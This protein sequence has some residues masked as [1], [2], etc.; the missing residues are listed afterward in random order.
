MDPCTEIATR[1]VS[2][3]WALRDLF[4]TAF[5]VKD[6]DLDQ[7]HEKVG[8]DIALLGRLRSLAR[9]HIAERWPFSEAS[10]RTPKGWQRIVR[11]RD[12]QFTP[13]D[14]LLKDI[15]TAR[16]RAEGQKLRTTPFSRVTGALADGLNLMSGETTPADL[17]ALRELVLADFKAHSKA[18][19]GLFPHVP[20]QFVVTNAAAMSRVEMTRESLADTVATE[21]LQR[22]LL[23]RVALDLDY[24]P[25]LVRV[26]DGG[27]D[28]LEDPAYPRRLV[29]QCKSANHAVPFQ[30][31]LH[32][33]LDE[34]DRSRQLRRGGPAPQDTA[35]LTLS[36]A[37]SR[38]LLGLAFSGGGIRS[39]TFNL[40]ILQGLA[41]K[42]WLPQFDYLSTVS[43]G[44]YIGSWL[45]A[46]IKRRGSVAAV[47]ESLRG[48]AVEQNPI[49]QRNPDPGAE[50]V[51]P[52]RLL[53][54]YSN[55][56]APRLG[57]FS[58]DSWTIVS[59]WMRNTIMNL[60]VLTLFLMA[61]LIGPRLLG[62]AFDGADLW[63]SLLCVVV[64]LGL[65]SILIGFN[66]RSF[67]DP[68]TTHSENH[69]W[70]LFRPRLK[71]SERGDTPFTV[72]ATI[73]VPLVIA[74][75]F[76]MRVLWQYAA[77]STPTS[78]NWKEREGEVFFWAF[79]LL[80]SGLAV[81]ALIGRF[82]KIPTR[83][84]RLT[85]NAWIWRIV[86]NSPGFFKSVLWGALSA[87]VGALLI[88][89]LWKRLLPLLFADS[90]RGIWVGIGFGPVV[91]LAVIALVLVIYLGL[92]G[93]SAPDERRE[94]WSRLGAWLGLIGGAWAVVTF[95]SFFVPYLV[96]SAWLYT[97]TLGLGWGALT[98]TGAWLASSGESNGINLRLDKKPLPSFVI[99]IAPYLFILGVFVVV[100]ALTHAALYLLQQES[101]MALFR[102]TY[103]AMGALPFSVQRYA[104]T[105]WAFVEPN[106]KAPAILCVL[107]LGLAALLSWRVDVNEFS[108]HHF[109]KNR[110][111]R[112]YLGAS[113]TR[114][115]RR[116]NA[117]TGLD[118]DD[119]IKLWRFSTEDR[120][121]P[122]DERTD[123]R[124][125]FAGPYPIINTTLNLTT[126]DELAWQQRKGQSFVFTP[127]YSGFD[128]ATKQSLI[129]EKAAAQFAYR[130]TRTFGNFWRHQSPLEC[131][132]SIGT[133][134]AI[135][136]AAA[137]PN[138]GYHSSPAVAFLLTILNARLGWW[139]GNPLNDS[140]NRPSPPFGLFYILSE[141]FGFAGVKRKFVNLSDGG[142]FD[143][144]GLYELIRRRCRFIILCDGEQDDRYSFN[145]LA[146]AIRKCR[147]DFGVVI[148]LST[149][150]IDPTN[151]HNG[152]DNDRNNGEPGHRKANSRHHVAVGSINY[153]GQGR[154]TLIY[155]KASL[156]GDEPSDVQ[157]YRNRHPEFPH[158]T[159]A[160]QFF[161]E[162]QFESYR[163]LGQHIVD[164]TFN[165]WSAPSDD[166]SFSDE[167]EDLVGAIRQKCE[168][169]T[170]S[171]PTTV[172]AEQH[173]KEL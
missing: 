2:Y 28:L 7:L 40:G 6:F 148:D 78:T 4:P 56:L 126:G 140:W 128:F 85:K 57:A 106:S 109:Y 86:K 119:D 95:V 49:A 42:G 30:L 51:R 87:L 103:T 116:P 138:A 25:L 134:V 158:Q 163:A 26:V 10:L 157:E 9:R 37:H 113:R 160:D 74:A 75:F 120:S 151:G 99:T 145:G 44:G 110:L 16:L 59:I 12:T 48:Y 101:P 88:V 66:L 1:V 36:R 112:A 55:Y 164:Q 122:D 123:C 153:P 33:E 149:K 27:S 161:D 29:A 150:W 14:H 105:Y 72:I 47:Q 45:L 141:L 52:I 146:G 3:F 139:I 34:I 127:L 104:D 89:Q 63:W 18:L 21:M 154:G 108:M 172:G 53:R 19:I 98:G 152:G 70:R 43:G 111:V 135:S 17:K 173:R 168:T 97:G 144:M 84:E 20:I 8:S 15:V 90:H 117:F 137:N 115:N 96:A 129:A 81:T 31:V 130:P 159:T 71:P 67:D 131:G 143:N 118:M 22:Q 80:A 73:V 169:A 167:L 107:L 58:A 100:A 62:V 65:T 114:V 82:W 77:A 5:T 54:E 35:H 125:A 142:H 68:L 102:Q 60:L 124:P 156:T 170:T 132:I 13:L 11:H 92:E 166:R 61:V 41:G 38:S 171:A 79:G 133:A 94:W 147:V 24:R 39:A 136:G 162:S 76:G 64:F 121:T 46:W 50:H 83:G 32:D 91:L 165:A 93:L 23:Y 69:E 155:I